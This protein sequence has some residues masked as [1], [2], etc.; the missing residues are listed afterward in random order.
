M[1]A[2][3]RWLI[4]VGSALFLVVFFVFFTG[5]AV[6]VAEAADGLVPGSRPYVLWSL[7]A[8]LATFL[9]LPVVLYFR[10]PPPL[11]PPKTDDPAAVEAHLRALRKRLAANS[12]TSGR[13][14]ESREEVEAALDHLASEADEL[15]QK[16]ARNVFLIT[17]ISPNGRFDLLTVLV[18]QSRLVWNISKLYSQRPTV[19]DLT[20]L[21]A[22]VAASAFVAGGIEDIDLSEQ[23]QPLVAAALPSASGAIPGFG[24]AAAVVANAI[25]SGATNAYLT[26]RVGIVTRRYCGSL[27]RPEKSTLRRAAILEAGGLLLKVIGSNAIAIGRALVGGTAKAGLGQA[28]RLGAQ[29]RETT[30]AQA[31]RVGGYVKEMG[32]SLAARIGRGEAEGQDDGVADPEGPLESATGSGDRRTSPEEQE[33]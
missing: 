16:T 14:L 3:L 33:A 8:L 26:L 13:T 21:Y 28:T 17:A 30:S 25:T 15:T 4:V 20:T 12:R 9:T 5:Q 18:A 7:A 29:V 19:R 22:N 23:V 10:L 2:R 24:G 27:V 11:L 6:Q 31:S 1:L 32:D